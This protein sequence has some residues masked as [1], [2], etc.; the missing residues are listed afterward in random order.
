MGPA[1]AQVSNTL[2]IDFESPVLPHPQMDYTQTIDTGNYS[3]YPFFGRKNPDSSFNGFTYSNIVDS[4]GIDSLERRAAFP[5]SG[6][7]HSAQYAVAHGADLGVWCGVLAG[8]K[9]TGIGEPN[10]QYGFYVTNITYNVLGMLHGDSMSKKFGG[11]SGTDPDWLL[12]TIKG[13]EYGQ[14]VDSTLF[15]LADFRSDTPARDYIVKDWQW[16]DLY[17]WLPVDSLS[18]SLSSSDTDSTGLMRTPA[19]FCLDNIES[20]MPPGEIHEVYQNGLFKIY[21]NPVASGGRLCVERQQG[22][23]AKEYAVSLYNLSGE[24]V[25]QQQLDPETSLALP[26]L[27]PGIYTLLMHNDQQ[28][29]IY[30]QKLLVQ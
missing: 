5:G 19:Y 16:V 3:F 15:Y 21:P 9:P 22:I 10:W 11:T 20:G 26:Q 2:F 23:F 24:K 28:E 30:S 12:L 25:M 13:Y 4:L 7:N 8:Q 14:L 17:N 18:F 1:I 6:H 29:L 27:P